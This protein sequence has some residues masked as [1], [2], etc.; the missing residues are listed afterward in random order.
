MTGNAID[1]LRELLDAV[2]SR[3][4]ALESHCGITSTASSPTKNAPALQ[5]TPSSRH[6]SGDCTLRFSSFI[7]EVVTIPLCARYCFILFVH[8]CDRPSHNVLL[9][10]DNPKPN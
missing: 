7:N 5:K 3:L 6:I 9:I 8:C 2:T 10:I 4:A 1:P